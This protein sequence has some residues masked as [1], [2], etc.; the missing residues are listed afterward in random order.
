MVSDSTQEITLVEF[1]YNIRV[2]YP[3]LYKMKYYSFPTAYPYFFLFFNQ[4]NIVQQSEWK[5]ELFF[6]KMLFMLTGNRC[7]VF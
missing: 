5:T 4:T 6:N 7:I 3:Q 2:E 1:W